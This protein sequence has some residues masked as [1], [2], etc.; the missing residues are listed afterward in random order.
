MLSAPP[1]P[2]GSGNLLLGVL[3]MRLGRY[4]EQIRTHLQHEPVVGRSAKSLLFLAT[5][6]HDVA[7]PQTRSIEEAGR[8]RYFN[9]DQVGAE[10]IRQRARFFR[11]SNTEIDRLETIIRDH[12]RPSF[13]SH[14]KG[15]PSR[16]AI[17]RFFRDTGQAGI[18]ICLLSLADVWATYGTTLPQER[19]EK[20]VDTVRTLLEA[21]WEGQEE[22]VRPPALV[23]GHDLINHLNLK[24]GPLIGEILEALREAQVEKEVNTPQEALI[25]CEEYLEKGQQ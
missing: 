13:L 16:R 6:Y 3:S 7:K 20:Q 4:R 18:D 10:I 19:W 25:F 8:I 5:L 17:Y 22:Q 2:D 9:H 12:M 24:P 1:D 15:G 14:T 23:S 21:W 11:L